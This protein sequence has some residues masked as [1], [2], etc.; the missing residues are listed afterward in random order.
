MRLLLLILCIIEFLFVTFCENIAGIIISPL[1][2]FSSSIAIAIVYLKISNKST[3]PVIKEKN[4]KIELYT[5]T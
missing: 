5:T 2:F 3:T 1:L 4:K